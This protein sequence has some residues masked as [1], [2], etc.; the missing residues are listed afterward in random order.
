MLFGFNRTTVQLFKVQGDIVISTFNLAAISFWSVFIRFYQ[1]QF[2]FV[3]GKIRVGRNKKL[4]CGKND[5][6]LFL[7]SED[8]YFKAGSKIFHFQ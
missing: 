6:V 5:F 4:F 2:I 8:A 7:K 3:V 1:C